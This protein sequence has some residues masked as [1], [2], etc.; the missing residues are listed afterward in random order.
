M[1]GRTKIEWAS[2]TWNPVVGCEPVSPG[3]RNC[4]AARMASRF[5]GEGER[6]ENIARGGKWTG[7][8]SKHRDKLAAPLRWRRARAVFVCSMGDLFFHG[9]PDDLRLE[10]FFTMQEATGHTFLILT[11]RARAMADWVERAIERFAPD[12]QAH[13]MDNVWWGVTVEDQKR[14]DERVP[15]LQSMPV[16]RRFVSCEPLIAPVNLNLHLDTQRPRLDWIIGGGESGAG[17]RPTHPDWARRLRNSALDFGV[18]FMWKQWGAW[19]PSGP[20]EAAQLAVDR[21]GR[22]AN[23]PT[24]RATYPPDADASDGWQVM[25][26]VGKTT[27]GRALDDETLD[28]F[29]EGMP[30]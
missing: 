9:V 23:D 11:K 19:A 13:A 26:K 8:V 18:P 15:I 30:R 27:A 21:E 17:A 6:W 25:Y 20:A 4:Y 7:L 16:Q 29:P 14:A 1:A 2:A 22:I 24:D 28:A 12:F 3:C 10:M 5:G